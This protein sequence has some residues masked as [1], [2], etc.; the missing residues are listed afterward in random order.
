M[1]GQRRQ[2]DWEDFEDRARQP[3]GPDGVGQR[4]SRGP[5]GPRGSRRG[6]PQ[7]YSDL[8]MRGG[9]RQPASNVPGSREGQVNG[10]RSRFVALLVLAVAAVVV[11][12]GGIAASSGDAA[13]GSSVSVSL[14]PFPR[15]TVTSATQ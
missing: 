7:N 2:G 14:L 9:H 4:R 8:A 12:I 10:G 13:G 1:S 5:Q 3:L 15:N 6:H 11:I